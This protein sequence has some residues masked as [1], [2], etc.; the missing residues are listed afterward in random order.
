[1][2]YELPEGH[3]LPNRVMEDLNL[4]PQDGGKPS[5]TDIQYDALV[6]GVAG[7]NSILAVAPISTG[8]TNI[9][10]W[11]LLSWISNLSRERA[12]AVYLV[13]HRALARQKFDEFRSSLVDEHFGGDLGAV[14]LATGDGVEDGTGAVAQDP[15]DA[16]LLVATYEK[17]LGLLSASGV[18]RDMSHVLVICDE[19]QI[20]G[21]K[22]RGRNIEI[23]LTLLK[24]SGIGQLIAL[25]AV[26]AKDDAQKLSDWLDLR[27]VYSSA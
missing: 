14:V 10:I 11:G 15:L 18:N 25:S 20:L 24:N 9:A 16:P 5:I 12:S 19:I 27:L 17:Y 2:K 7:G 1:M 6:A 3:G 13:S 23:L 21:D 26:I 8:K 22:T 4:L